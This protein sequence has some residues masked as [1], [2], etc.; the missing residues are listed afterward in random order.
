MWGGYG[1]TF[2]WIDPAEDLVAVMMSQR[3]GPSRAYYRRLTKQMVYQAIT[4]SAQ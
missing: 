4:E 3:A 2:F 1:G